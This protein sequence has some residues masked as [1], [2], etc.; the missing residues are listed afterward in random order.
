MLGTLFSLYIFFK[1]TTMEAELGL[2][3]VHMYILFIRILLL[4]FKCM[5]FCFCKL[6]RTVTCTYVTKVS[7][8]HMCND[9]DT[10]G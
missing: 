3:F 10:G 6:M 9:S 7:R 1:L 2:P 8:H 4:L 5:Y